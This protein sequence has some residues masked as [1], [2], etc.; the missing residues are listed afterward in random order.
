M[1]GLKGRGG[2]ILFLA[3]AL[4]MLIMVITAVGSGLAPIKLLRDYRDLSESDSLFILRYDPSVS[5]PAIVPLSR[6]RSFR[7]A[8]ITLSEWDSIQPVIDIRDSTI[9][10]TIHGVTIHRSKMEVVRVDPFLRR[11]PQR[12]YT[13]L[14]TAP[15][16]ILDQ[17]ATIVKEPVVIREAPRDTIEAVL[18][19]Y[20]PDTLVQRPAFLELEL[21][22]GIR[23][24]MEQNDPPRFRDRHVRFWFRFGI[25]ARHATGNLTRT[26]CLRSPGYSPRIVVRLPANQLRAIYRAL[27]DQA[28][29]VVAY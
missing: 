25:L 2:A 26:L 9:Q 28:V 1:L 14:F 5:H 3:G 17:R 13:R 20:K 6:E 22:H 16:R 4:V 29:M 15:V 18:N 27:P 24:I 12:E 19:A 7:E 10:L 23:I 21:E 8:L 11:L